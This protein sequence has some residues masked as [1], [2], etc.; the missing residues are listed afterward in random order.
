MQASLLLARKLTVFLFTFFA[1]AMQGF[2]ANRPSYYNNAANN[3]NFNPVLGFHGS[4]SMNILA[5][6]LPLTTSPRTFSVATPAS[7]S[8]FSAVF[9]Y[10][11]SD[12]T[13]GM[14]II[15]VRGQ[16]AGQIIKVI[17]TPLD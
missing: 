1:D 12:M 2:T 5:T 8:G 4:Q 7:T 11:P 6:L 16:D 10:G 15:T 3:I 17:K 9:A 14:Y 13:Q